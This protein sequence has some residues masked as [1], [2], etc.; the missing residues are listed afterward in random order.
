MA[1]IFTT[2]LS[3]GLIIYVVRA[4]ASDDGLANV[5]LLGGTTALLLLCVFTV[6]N[7]ALLVL[8]KRAGRPRP[9]PGADVPA[10]DRC[11]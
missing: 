2:L 4:S 9:L 3:F 1:I 6:V 5:T 8:R 11:A 10:G 7:V